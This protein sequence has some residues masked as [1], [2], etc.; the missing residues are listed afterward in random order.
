MTTPWNYAAVNECLFF[1][2]FVFFPL[3]QRWKNDSNLYFLPSKFLFLSLVQ[4]LEIIYFHPI[5]F[6]EIDS[7]IVEL[8]EEQR[9]TSK[10]TKWKSQRAERKYVYPEKV[11]Q[12][13]VRSWHN[14]WKV[15]TKNNTRIRLVNESKA[16]GE[17]NERQGGKNRRK[18]NN[19]KT[20]A[21]LY[22]LRNFEELKAPRTPRL[23]LQGTTDQK[24]SREL[25][26]PLF[27]LSFWKYSVFSRATSSGTMQI[28]VW[29]SRWWGTD[30]R[31]YFLGKT[32]WNKK[33]W[34]LM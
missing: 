2:S 17:K 12:K 29:K 25:V 20:V 19:K 11:N 31:R 23:A 33:S 34:L 16:P 9:N 7:K 13:E 21:F 6:C 32:A 22:R 26:S 4:E 27:L 10:R 28:T 18:H 15:K 14:M 3:S 24:E 8:G 1:L 30:H 5:F